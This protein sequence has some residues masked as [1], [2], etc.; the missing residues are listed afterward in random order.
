MCVVS[1][2]CG[3][4]WGPKEALILT[5]LR[6]LALRTT[7]TPE[8]DNR[9]KEATEFGGKEGTR[10]DHAFYNKQKTEIGKNDIANKRL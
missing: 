5:V 10:L 8:D 6:T 9:I 2:R 4:L 3:S 7:T 1:R